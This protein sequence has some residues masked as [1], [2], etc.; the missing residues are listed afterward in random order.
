MKIFGKNLFTDAKLLPIMQ[1][2]TGERGFKPFECVG[3]RKESSAA[4]YL[5]WKKRGEQFSAK[6]PILL[7]YFEEKILPKYP[8]LKENSKKILDVWN[9]QN[10]LP[11]EYESYIN[12]NL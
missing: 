6:L 2:L 4:F 8:N 12:Q 5:S 1:Q 7:R 9:K 11:K 10:N 3:T